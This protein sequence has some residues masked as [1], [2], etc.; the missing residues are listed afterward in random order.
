MPGAEPRYADLHKL[1]DGS[2]LA[3]QRKP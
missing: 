3:V 2:G 1:L